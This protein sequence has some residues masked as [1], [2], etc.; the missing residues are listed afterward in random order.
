MPAV[1]PVVAVLDDEAEM[2]KAFR[3]L[4][5]CRGYQVR[6]YARAEDLIGDLATNPPGCILLDLH[7]PG[8]NGFDV[9][10]TLR[11]RQQDIP[12]IAVTAHDEP[13]TELRVRAL[14]A[15][16]YLKKPVDRDT[17]LSAMG[18]AGYHA[19]GDRSPNLKPE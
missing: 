6:E 4:L 12:T 17:L 7:M 13:G 15:V 11:A 3:R 9:L 10:E 19:T 2:R 14:G 16:A 8:A 1:L 5:G 18:L